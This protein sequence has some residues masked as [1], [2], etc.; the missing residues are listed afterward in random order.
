[1]PGGVGGRRGQ[2]R[3]LP[4]VVLLVCGQPGLAQ[5]PARYVDIS[6]DDFKA[7][8]SIVRKILE[9][10]KKGGF[11]EFKKL[12]EKHYVTGF[13]GISFFK[14]VMARYEQIFGKSRDIKYV[15]HV[16]IKNVTDYYVFYY[17][18]LRELSLIPWELSFYKVKGEWK[19][20][21]IRTEAGSPVEFFKFC[22]L[23]YKSFT[24]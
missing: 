16:S 22:E 13:E 7:I 9:P 8:D 19:I 6:Q 17:A 24:K 18:D 21:G 15:R 2:P 1:M 10:L 11:E 23:Q 12:C 14:P 20:N 5:Q 4:D 3:L